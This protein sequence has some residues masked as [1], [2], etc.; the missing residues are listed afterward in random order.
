[1]EHIER[2]INK[3][4]TSIDSFGDGLKELKTVLIGNKEYSQKGLVDDVDEIK[5][6]F[7]PW[8]IGKKR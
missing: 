2:S 7:A 3:M 6:N 8:S 1:M 4:E 5:K